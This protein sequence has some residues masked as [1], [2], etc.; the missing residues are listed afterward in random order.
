M[1]SE[2]KCAVCAL[3]VP[4]HSPTAADPLDT[5]RRPHCNKTAERFRYYWNHSDEKV[6]ADKNCLRASQQGQPAI[7]KSHSALSEITDSDPDWEQPELKGTSLTVCKSSAGFI[8]S[9]QTLL[10]W[11]VL[12]LITVYDVQ[13]RTHSHCTIKSDLWDSGF[14]DFGSFIFSPSEDST[15]QILITTEDKT[16][17]W[18][19]IG[20]FIIHKGMIDDPLPSY[21]Y[22]FSHSLGRVFNFCPCFAD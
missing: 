21:F 10:I 22:R 15:A 8:L 6:T 1:A 4:W 5:W 18:S 9:L 11:E 17:S 20:L 7:F 16:T 13:T 3:I 14:N 12:W 2:W 19:L